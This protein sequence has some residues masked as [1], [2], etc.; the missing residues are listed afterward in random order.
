[1]NSTE[2]DVQTPVENIVPEARR[3]YSRSLLNIAIY[4]ALAVVAKMLIGMFLP[5]DASQTIKYLSSFIPMYLFAFPL[6]LLISKPLPTAKPETHSMTLPQIILA[7]FACECLA[8]GG[9]FIGIIVNVILSMLLKFSTQ[10]TFLF[11]GVFGDSSLVFLFA[12]VLVAPVV[13]EMIFRKTLIDRVRKYG[14]KTAILLSGLMFGMFHGNFSQFFY[15]AGVGLLFAWIYVRTGKIQHTIILHVLLNFWGSA[16]PLLMLRNVDMNLIREVAESNNYSSLF[17]N[18][19]QFIPFFIY[20]GLTYLLAFVGLVLL[21]LNF[22]KLTVDP[23]IAPVPKGKRFSAACINI[24]FFALFAA[25][26]YSF[27]SQ[28]FG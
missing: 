11:E 6:Y 25:C 23:P 3:A 4:W 21:V 27:V 7:F 18:I 14:D 17:A 9:N 24:G 22:R 16:M 26:V 28:L 20:V 13:E 15:A 10:S 5:K 2:T 1:M 12:A 8:I 19:N